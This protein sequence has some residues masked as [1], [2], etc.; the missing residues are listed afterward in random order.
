MILEKLEKL[1]D[2]WTEVGQYYL[3]QTKGLQDRIINPPAVGPG[4]HP[5]VETKPKA[6][7]GR[8][9][10]EVVEVVD[11][12]P[13]GVAAAP[14]N[15]ES[16]KVDAEDIFEARRQAQEVIG[17]FIRRHLKATPPGLAQAKAII[18]KV[19][20]SEAGK[21]LED[22]AHESNLLL[23]ARFEKELDAV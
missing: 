11:N 23:I 2:V 21:Q 7:R 19:C 20:P 6:A 8:P 22:F 9:K 16:T 10:K 5:D 4:V 3:A 1:I 12:D 15:V 18:A 17:A 14:K 13:F